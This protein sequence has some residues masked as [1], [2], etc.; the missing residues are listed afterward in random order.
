[1]AE[2][3]IAEAGEEKGE[4]RIDFFDPHFHIWGPP[5]HDMDI[6]FA[7]GGEDPHYGVDRYEAEFNAAGY[8]SSSA[9]GAADGGGGEPADG[10][11]PRFRVVHAGGVFVEA[12][13]VCFPSMPAEELNVKC[14]EEATFASDSLATSTKL[15]TV[16]G[17]LCLED[18]AVEEHM[19]A[20]VKDGPVDILLTSEW[21]SELNAELGAGEDA[22]RPNLPDPGS[23]VSPAVAELAR[24]LEPRYHFFAQ[25]KQFYKRRPFVVPSEHHLCSS[26]ALAGVDSKKGFHAIALSNTVRD[27]PR[28]VLFKERK[29]A[30][31]CPYNEGVLSQITR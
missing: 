7:P 6:L 8:V 5:I 12:L 19:K 11:A 21:P 13:S 23:C 30:T 22:T 24:A 20:L 1:M 31:P 25:G 15:Y 9:A 17:S 26:I 18:A 2:G 27:S 28:E 3:K 10:G 4:I 14:L 29:L 16:V